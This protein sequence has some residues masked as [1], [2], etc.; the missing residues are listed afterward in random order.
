M[1]KFWLIAKMSTYCTG[2]VRSERI[3]S[4]LMQLT[5]Y[6]LTSDPLSNVYNADIRVVEDSSVRAPLW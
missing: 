6:A 1:E 3:S 5:K 4:K 2:R